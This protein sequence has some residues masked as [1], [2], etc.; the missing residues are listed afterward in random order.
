MKIL[1]TNCWQSDN[2]GDNAIW[3]NM[4]INLRGAFPECEFFIASQ[5]TL[6]WDMD[7]LKEFEPIVVPLDW[8]N[9]LSQMDVIISQGGG[10]MIQ[11]G[12]SGFLHGFKKAQALGKPTF[13]ATQTFLGPINKNTQK[14]LKKVLNKADLVVAREKETRQL[15]VDSGVKNIKVLPDQVFTIKPEKYN[16]PL[17][18]N[19]VKIGIRG[20]S[21]SESVLSEVASCADM[22]VEAIAPV[23][24]VSIG[25]GGDRDDR[26]GARQVSELMKH[27]NIVIEDKVSANELMDIGKGGIFISDRYHGIVYALSMGTPVIALTPDI[28]FKMP[29]LLKKFKYP[30]RKVPRPCPFFQGWCVRK[31]FG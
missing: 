19:A 31:S 26:V 15:M 14:L 4:M 28:G 24:L 17:P 10:Y 9:N 1:F 29:G 16:K 6:S 11:D 25:H 27:E 22:I 7:Q 13:F 3:R 21:A 12:M 8:W 30:I 20:Y 18:K 2:T 5:K 23:V